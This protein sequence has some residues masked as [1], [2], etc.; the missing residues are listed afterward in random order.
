MG[1]K[2]WVIGGPIGYL[3]EELLKSDNDND[4]HDSDSIS[5]NEVIRIQQLIENGRKSG[6]ASIE[7][8]ISDSFARGLEING[9]ANVEAIPINVG[10]KIQRDRNG[11]FILKVEY[12][13]AESIDKIRKLHQM[14]SEG[15]L[16]EEEFTQAKQQALKSI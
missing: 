4:P 14:Y 5:E 6:V 10:T 13:P 2:G 11:N 8:E 15:I 9:Q 7:I 1:W 12:L 3:A 16:T